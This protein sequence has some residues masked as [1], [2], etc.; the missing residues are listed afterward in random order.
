M[1]KTTLK[2]TLLVCA[3]KTANWLKDPSN[4]FSILSGDAGILGTSLGE[5]IQEIKDVTIQW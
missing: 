1:L 2:S 3:E 5:T 4:L